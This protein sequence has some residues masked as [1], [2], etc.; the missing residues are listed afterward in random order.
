MMELSILANGID[1]L[2]NELLEKLVILDNG[3]SALINGLLE[4]VAWLIRLM[5]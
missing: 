1:S 2:I 4:K 5:P 3:T